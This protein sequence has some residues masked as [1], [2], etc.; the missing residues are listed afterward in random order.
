[1]RGQV[2]EDG[3]TLVVR[4]GRNAPVKQEEAQAALERKR[5]EEEEKRKRGGNVGFYRF[6]SREARKEEARRLV[7]RVQVDRRR[8][9]ERKGRR[10]FRPL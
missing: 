2:D 6:Q 9:E 1:M 4:G 8:V 7:E 5:K 3:F 10:K